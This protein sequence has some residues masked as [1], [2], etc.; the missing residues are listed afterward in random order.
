[1]NRAFTGVEV[2]SIRSLGLRDAKDREVF[3]AAREVDAVVMSKDSDFVWLLE[4]HGAPPRLIWVRCG[5]TSNARMRAVLS[6]QLRHVMDLLE[7]GEVLVE[8][9]DA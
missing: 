8:I 6:A 7:S 4:Q 3:F 5:N 1:M 2:Q 9:V